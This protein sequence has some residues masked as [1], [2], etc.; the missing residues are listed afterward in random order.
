MT[1]QALIPR[2]FEHSPASTA[3]IRRSITAFA[4]DRFRFHREATLAIASMEATMA[5]TP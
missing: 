3:M 5:T 2:K 4:S 1:A